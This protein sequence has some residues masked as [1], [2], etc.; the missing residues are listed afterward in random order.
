[1]FLSYLSYIQVDPYVKEPKNRFLFEQLESLVQARDD[2]II[3]I[4][5]SEK[6]VKW[7]YCNYHIIIIV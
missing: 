3:Q 1:M 2:T 7:L 5:Q 4:R 6:E